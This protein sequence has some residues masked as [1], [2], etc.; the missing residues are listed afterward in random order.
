MVSEFDLIRR[1]FTH[2]ARNAVLGVG[3]DAAL[4]RP[5]PGME[6]AVSTDMLVAG[7]H[8]FSDDD[9]RQLGH[10]A[11]AV[12]LSDMAA[13]G[14]I[15]RWAT[16]SLAL[17]EADEGWLKGFAEGFLETAHKYSVELIGGDTT[18]GPL[19]ICVQIMGEVSAGMALRRDGAKSGDE[20]WVSG[21]LGDAALAL[22]HLQRRIELT[23]P[24][25][26]ACLPALHMPSPRVALGEALVGVARSAIDISDGLLADLSHILESSGV[27]AEVAFAA[28]PASTVLRARLHEEVARNCLLAGGDDYELCF[29]A[30][31]SRREDILALS[32]RL[33]LP[34]T[35]VGIIREG[36]GLRLLDAE[37]KDMPIGALGFDHF[38]A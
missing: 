23:P 16:L 6:V 17:P 4:I 30:P 2:P 32:R 22:A 13:M 9:P 19:N 8:F 29:T 37:G 12:N 36:S 5:T 20:I 28:L 21:H 3:D 15:P 14:A 11:L 18:R 7:K 1:Y 27:A 10:K 24:D 31:P 33:E 34:L 38:A 26:A 25:A 35:A